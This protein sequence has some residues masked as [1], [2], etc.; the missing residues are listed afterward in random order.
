MAEW[1]DATHTRLRELWD[2]GL[3]AEKIGRQLGFTKNAVLGKA[4]RLRLTPRAAVVVRK[5]EPMDA[6]KTELARI[7]WHDRKEL[8][9]PDIARILGVS[10][11]VLRGKAFRLN[12]PARGFAKS[13]RVAVA[14]TI[15]VPPATDA[16]QP[17]FL[18]PPSDGVVFKPRPPGACCWPL[19]GH[20]DKPTH[21]YCDGPSLVGMTYCPEH[22][23]VAYAGT[24][25]TGG[26]FQLRMIG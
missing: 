10:I 19:W 26:R 20:N 9:V 4:R 16:A 17:F 5:A 6:A 24:A 13:Y 25:A 22:A 14:K 3:S 23:S 15:T 8:S 18:T 21:R 12:W 11:D 2:E 1:N 7:M